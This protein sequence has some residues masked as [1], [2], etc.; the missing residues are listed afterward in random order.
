M[1]TG[2]KTNSIAVSKQLW[3]FTFIQT[4]NSFL[5]GIEGRIWIVILINLATCNITTQA[6]DV[7]DYYEAEGL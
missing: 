1:L 6:S 7:L 2:L 5:E 4:K 3:N